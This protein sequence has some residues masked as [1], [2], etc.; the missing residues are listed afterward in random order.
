MD[1][2]IRM[3]RIGTAFVH[4]GTVDHPLMPITSTAIVPRYC[5]SAFAWRCLRPWGFA[6]RWLYGFLRVRGERIA[7]SGVGFRR[8]KRLCLF[9]FGE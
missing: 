2:L 5:L 7:G 1:L 4:Q 3:S 6:I 8:L 9:W